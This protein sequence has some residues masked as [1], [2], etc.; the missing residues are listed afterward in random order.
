MNDIHGLYA[1]KHRQ[2]LIDNIGKVIEKYFYH[3]YSIDMEEDRV[4][5][6]VTIEKD[7][8]KEFLVMV[9]G[10]VKN[11]RGINISISNQSLLIRSEGCYGSVAHSS[12]QRTDDNFERIVP[13][14]KNVNPK[15]A[16][17]FFDNGNLYVRMPKI[18][19]VQGEVLEIS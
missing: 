5:P 18:H 2:S 19:N 11:D 3:Y 14:P 4:A 12:H 15:K 6:S 7:D 10:S 8:A 16:E 1:D 13:L 17:A 9:I